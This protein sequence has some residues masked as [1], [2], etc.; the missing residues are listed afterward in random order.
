MRSFHFIDENEAS[1][2]ENT[3][4]FPTIDPNEKDIENYIEHYRLAHLF[5][6]D[7]FIIAI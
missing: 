4:K 2:L 7:Y 5:S 3:C 1:L 6:I